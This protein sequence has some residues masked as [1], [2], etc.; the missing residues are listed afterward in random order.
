MA[1]Y[2]AAVDGEIEFFPTQREALSWIRQ[3][4]GN[5]ELTCFRRELRWDVREGGIVQESER[6]T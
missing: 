6:L 2:G 3:Q 1:G 5:G 4:G